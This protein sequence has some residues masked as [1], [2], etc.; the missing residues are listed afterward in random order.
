MSPGAS[1][2]RQN[3]SFPAPTKVNLRLSPDRSNRKSRIQPLTPL[4][5]CGYAACPRFPDRSR[6]GPRRSPGR[7]PVTR[8]SILIPFLGNRDSLENTLASVLQ[9]RP[10]G[11]EIVVALGHEYDDPYQLG[12][13][14]RFVRSD[15]SPTLLAALN[16]GLDACRGPIVQTLACGA[17]VSDGWTDQALRRF[18]DRRIASVAPLIV[19]A[20]EPQRIW[21]AGLE[22]RASG[23]CRRRGQ[24][25]WA[26]SAQSLNGR[27]V[28]P[29]L[30]A[31]FYRRSALGDRSKAFDPALG[32]DFADV[33]L[34]LR[35]LEAGY[36]TACE[37]DSIVLQSQQ[38]PQTSGGWTQAR[39]AE[40]LFWRHLSIYGRLHSL[41][42]HLPTVAGE[43]ARDLPRAKAFAQ[44]AGRCL[45]GCE[46]GATRRQSL[47]M[48]LPPFNSPALGSTPLATAGKR[49]DAEGAGRGL[50]PPHFNLES[51]APRMEPRQQRTLRS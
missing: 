11:A 28:G 5:E 33:D 31:G 19:E 17:T 12:E 50:E 6:D 18:D 20:E 22:Y 23:E 2:A 45:A 51:R 43:F 44:L 15:A 1:W 48:A 39:H 49:T 29:S 13:E 21:A 8:L 27:L 30:V 46:W 32:P 9:N 34:A 16:Q 14:V 26:D 37:P 36:A 25:A 7:L 35:L 41:A 10:E 4:E 3:Y 24:G 40:R 47:Q 38:T 42:A